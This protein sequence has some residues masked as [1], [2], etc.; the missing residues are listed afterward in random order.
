MQ[1]MGRFGGITPWPGCE[2]EKNIRSFVGAE[3]SFLKLG[4]VLV[5]LCG[6]VSNFS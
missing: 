2:Q 6:D 1:G 3:L 4:S 5:G